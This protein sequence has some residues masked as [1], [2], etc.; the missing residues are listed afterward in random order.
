MMESLWQDVKLAARGLGKARGFTL[1][2]VLTLALGIGANTAMFTVLNAVL[3][4]TLPADDPQ[5]LAILSDPNAHGIGV[6][7]GSGTRHLFGWSEFEDLRDR[8]E[9]FS[10]LCAVDS[11]VRRLDLAV[12]GAATT[13]HLEQADVSLVSGD[14]FRVLG[15]RPAT[16]R[17]FSGEV[18]QVQ[19]ANPVAVLSYG[20]WKR[21]FALDPNVISHKIRIRQTTFHIIGVASPG[22]TGETVGTTTD[23]W[24]PLTMQNEVFPAWQSFL[25]RPADP[26]GKVEW[27][28]IIGRLKPGV[29]LAQARSAINLT[30]KQIRETEAAGLSSDR[31]REYLASTIN[32]TDGSRGANYLSD[33]VG[34]PLRVLMAVVGLVLLIACANVAN[35]V[36][37]RGASRQREIAVRLALGAG[38]RRLL[39]QLL[40]ESVLLAMIGGALGIV[41]A[42]WADAVLVHMVSTPSN[43]VLLD[44]NPDAKILAFTLAVSLLTGIL[45]GLAPGFRAAGLDLNAVMKSGSR[46][47]ARG[48]RTPGGR[49]LVAGQIALSL[50]VLIVAGLFLHSFTKLAEL[51]KLALPFTRK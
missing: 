6:G 20:Y 25:D 45:F 12:A 50:S 21:R 31:R 36:L 29:T 44:L 27:L 7:D 43:P 13:G 22:F 26:L 34:D 11:H 39:Q 37:A 51:A 41:L 17:T 4:R 2:A 38:R 33:T 47:V 32:L 30:A 18:D 16:G 42:Q 14:Y 35:L 49:I 48:A 28:Q 10:A 40:T 15:I 19:H 1:V 24:V 46:G 3:L 5:R 8:N 23:V 9:V